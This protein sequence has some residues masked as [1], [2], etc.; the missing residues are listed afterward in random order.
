MTAQLLSNNEEDSLESKNYLRLQKMV[1]TNPMLMGSMSSQ[2]GNGANCHNNYDFLA[3]DVNINQI[4]S[5]ER[6]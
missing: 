5:K 2:D 3:D 1:P 6:L 4:L